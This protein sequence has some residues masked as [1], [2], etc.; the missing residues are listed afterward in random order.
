MECEPPELKRCVST[1][2][3]HVDNFE[4]Y[5]YDIHETGDYVFLQYQEYTAM[6]NVLQEGDYGRH[7]GFYIMHQDTI[8]YQIHAPAESGDILDGSKV[9]E[10]VITDVSEGY[11]PTDIAPT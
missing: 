9:E 8:I 1:G 4:H 5:K 6:A 10:M 7:T 2:D 3:P 11:W